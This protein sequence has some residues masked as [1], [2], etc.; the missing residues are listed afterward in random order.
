MP[1]H[2]EREHDVEDVERADPD[3]LRAEQRRRGAVRPGRGRAGGTPRRLFQRARLPRRPAEPAGR[4]GRSSG[5]RLRARPQPSTAKT[6]PGPLD[7]EQ[8]A[9][10]GRCREDAHALDPARDDVRRGQLLRR[11]G[12]GGHERRLRRPRERDRRGRD[13]GERV[14][15]AAGGA[16]ARSSAAPWRPSSSACATV[17]DCGSTPGG[18]AA[19]GERRRERGE[20]PRGNE[21]RERDETRGRRSALLV[22]VDEHR[23]PGRQLGGVE[24]DERQLDAP[25]LA[26]SGRPSPGRGKRPCSACCSRY[27]TAALIT[28]STAGNSRTSALRPPSG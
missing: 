1:E 18:T 8:D 25:Q 19:V 26:D 21:L 11:A 28:R 2:A 10:R 27:S 23:D 22:R 24:R 15:R 16:S 9:G 12:E 4:E 13:R 20:E 14:R 7:A 17:A 6:V 5:D 3:E